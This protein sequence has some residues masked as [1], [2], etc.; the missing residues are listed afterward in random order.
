MA[1]DDTNQTARKKA[2]LALSSGIRNYQP[3]LDTAV[4]NLP[5]DYKVQEHVDAE[6]MEAIDAIIQKL[7]DRSVQKG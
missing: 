5:D 3:S 2:I 6:D 4:K 1:V 7:R